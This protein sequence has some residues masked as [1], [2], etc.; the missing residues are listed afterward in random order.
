MLNALDCIIIEGLWAPPFVRA[1]KLKW[2]P[3][4]SDLVG[5]LHKKNVILTEKFVT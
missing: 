2:K 4:Y 5:I 3:L 1:R